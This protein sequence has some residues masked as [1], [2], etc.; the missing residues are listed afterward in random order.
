MRYLLLF[1]ISAAPIAAQQDASGD[2]AKALLFEV[3]NKVVQTVNRLP[4]YMCTETTDRI[5]LVPERKVSIKSC[6]DL[7]SRRKRADWKVRK[8]KS[9]RFRLDVA[10]GGANE[11]YSW[12]GAN[13]FEDRELGDL[14][15]GGT[16]STGAF[17][18]FLGSIFGTGAADF[19]YQGDVNAAGRTLAEFGFSVSRAMS[20][21]RIGDKLHSAI[22]AY[23]GTFVVDP[24][25]FDLVRLTVMA[26][27]LP[28]EIN[29]C[30]EITTL[31]YA[32]VQLNNA[33]FLLPTNARLQ[34]V[35]RE[36]SELEN[37]TVFSGCHEFHTESSIHFD[38]APQDTTDSAKAVAK[39]LFLP[40]R[41]SLRIA[42][43]QAIDPATA[44]AGD[45]LK[46]KLTGP[47]KAKSGDVL[48][49]A[50][51]TV[52]GR[53]L[54]I[55]RLYGATSESLAVAYRLE[56]IEVNGVTQPF[57]ASLKPTVRRRARSGSSLAVGQ[58]LGTFDQMFDREDKGVSFL[59]FKDMQAGH[60][61]NAGVV[62]EGLTAAPRQP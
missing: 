10:T 7:A 30:Q 50:G 61:I 15:R 26:D 23:E 14:V 34:I 58:E 31:D 4:K 2:D 24:K 22:V 55:E 27:R 21:H 16:T 12:A 8:S 17:S 25:T 28:E 45:T 60:A 42:L 46:G 6:D 13:R 48:V 3:R 36:G 57:D 19:T 9:D 40:P 33:G 29:A 41:L 5:T 54:H 47:I 51:A 37:R 20:S 39:S 52:T 43:T 56:T 1:Y 49:P 53:I 44:A 32:N 38:S 35:D 62:I 11:M 18:A 59:E